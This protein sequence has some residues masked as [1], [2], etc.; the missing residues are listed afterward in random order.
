MGATR[1]PW[2]VVA[3]MLQL[4][5]LREVSTNQGILKK[6]RKQETK[7]H[8]EKERKR[9]SLLLVDILWLYVFHLPCATAFEQRQINK[10]EVLWQKTAQFIEHEERWDLIFHQ[11]SIVVLFF[12]LRCLMFKTIASVNKMKA[13]V[14]NCYASTCAELL[15]GLWH[16]IFVSKHW[17][18]PW[19]ALRFGLKALQ[20]G[21]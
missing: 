9:E 8:K 20:R 11:F 12:L 19:L 2:L 13:L 1:P 18:L 15:W 14:P 3:N 21:S 10:G 6:R 5:L 16:M 17:P 4:F 7:N